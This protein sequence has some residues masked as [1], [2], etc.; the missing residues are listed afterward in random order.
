MFSL[1]MVIESNRC[2]N[3]IPISGQ[4]GDILYLRAH[5]LLHLLKKLI[6][7][8]GVMS[9][10][11]SKVKWFFRAFFSI[12]EMALPARFMLKWLYALC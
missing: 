1:V 5:N 9:H 3:K 6:G 10:G 8:D 11:C 4:S 12:V 7:G 2:G